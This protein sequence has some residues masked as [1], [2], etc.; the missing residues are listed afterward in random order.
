MKKISFLFSFIGF[1]FLLIRV[2]INLLELYDFYNIYNL[3]SALSLFFLALS[4]ILN[5][6]NKNSLISILILTPAIVMI[7]YSIYFNQI[8]INSSIIGNEIALEIYRTI[9]NVF[10]LIPFMRRFQPIDGQLLVFNFV[11][12]L[13]IILILRKNTNKPKLL[14]L[15]PFYILMLVGALRLYFFRDPFINQIL[16]LVYYAEITSSFTGFYRIFKVK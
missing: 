10:N 13:S 16:I 12:F 9:P 8:G 11:T 15:I 14:D 5:K 6:N 2:I 7:I 4:V 1:S 3:L